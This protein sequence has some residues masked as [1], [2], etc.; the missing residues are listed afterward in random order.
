M[1]TTQQSPGPAREDRRGAAGTGSPTRLLS[2]ICPS[3]ILTLTNE[4]RGEYFYVVCCSGPWETLTTALIP[5]SCPLDGSGT[6]EPHMHRCKTTF[7]ASWLGQAR[8]P[9]LKVFDKYN[10]SKPAGHFCPSRILIAKSAPKSCF[11]RR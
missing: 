6:W 1:P 5:A 9:C 2:W 7:S 11:L 4:W 10:K 3:Q 8:M